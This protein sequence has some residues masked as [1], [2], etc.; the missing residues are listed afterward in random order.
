M[1]STTC[2]NCEKTLHPDAA[3]CAYC[4]QAAHTHRL[5]LHDIT[6]DTVHYIT[7]AD[8]SIFRLIAQLTTRP[9]IVAKEFIT[10]KRQQYFRPL[11]FFL[12]VA[13]IVVFFTSMF[14]QTN[15]SR[16]QKMEQAALRVSSPQ[17][18]QRLLV[19]AQ[20]VRT[21]NK[22]TGKYSNFINMVATP[23]LTILF[24]L[25]YRRR[26]NYVESLVANMYFTG[27]VMLLYA[28]LFV[29]LLH[30]LP[31][32]NNILLVLFF[33]FEI[34][35]RGYCYYQL[36]GKKGFKAGF[37]AY[38]ISLLTSIVWITITFSLIFAYMGWG[39]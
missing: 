28:I 12:I 5:S 36:A 37:T 35:Y 18:K 13:G 39:L 8:K 38:G 16:S 32:A 7:H 21:I 2:L 15:D 6:H 1:Q 3:Y 19:Q 17:E 20:R 22:I 11:N 27:F 30:L 24:W 4:G 33:V 31:A 9:G 10:G 34:L 29:P 26:F 23:L 14:Y 25:A